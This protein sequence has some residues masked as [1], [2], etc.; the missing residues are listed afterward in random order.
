MLRDSTVFIAEVKLKSPFGY[1]SPQCWEYVFDLANDCPR[2]D[3]L[4]I[5]T[6]ERWGGSWDHLKEARKRTNKPILAKGLHPTDDDVRKALDLG[7]NYALVVGRQV[8]NDLV[9]KCFIEPIDFRQLSA[10]PAWMMVVWNSRDLTTGNNKDMDFAAARYVFPGWL[11]QA[12]N[13]TSV[14]DV[15][16]DADAIIVGQELENFILSLEKAK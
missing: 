2:S 16:P 7:A 10:I 6:D 11:C 9:T 13:I 3:M 8:G 14:E 5:H 12:S 1:S 4:S 15:H